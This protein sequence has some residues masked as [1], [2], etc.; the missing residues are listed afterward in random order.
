MS[1]ETWAAV[2][3]WEINGDVAEYQG[4]RQG[5]EDAGRLIADVYLDRG[6]VGTTVSFG[7]GSSGAQARVI[8][9]YQPATGSYYTAGLG[10]HDAHYALD[11]YTE[12]GGLHR[13][14]TRGRPPVGDFDGPVP[15]VVGVKQR[16]VTLTVNQAPV[17]EAT[18]PA[19][20]RRAQVGLFAWAETTVT[21]KGFELTHEPPA[22]FVVMQYG[23]KYDA[24]YT[25]LIKPIAAQALDAHG[26]E[27]FTVEV[28]RVDERLDPGVITDDI[29]RQISEAA[30]VVA[31]VTPDNPNVFYEVGY[32]RAL[33]KPVIF[34]ARSGRDLPFDIMGNR[35][36]FYGSTDSARRRAEEKL[37]ASLASVLAGG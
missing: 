9:G 34:L 3:P 15:F 35:C 30:V 25:S 2:G 20:V 11:E 14:V 31:E 29:E 24:L 10:G 32:A 28:S 23:G 27:D 1:F 5:S 33:S 17:L 26:A 21:F 4:I 16:R 12:A 13:L 18:L 6:S 7:T 36:I 19:T 22:V 37:K 8:F